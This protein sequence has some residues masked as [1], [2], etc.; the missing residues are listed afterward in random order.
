MKR[1]VVVTEGE[2]DA[3]LLRALLGVEADDPE[4]AVVAAG[5]WSAADSLARS[6]LVV[7]GT[8]QSPHRRPGYGCCPEGRIQDHGAAGRSAGLT[9]SALN[10]GRARLA[11][12]RDLRIQAR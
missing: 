9:L 3:C 10:G 2:G 8:E 7:G 11:S 5:G 1:C 6:Y 4:V 12:I